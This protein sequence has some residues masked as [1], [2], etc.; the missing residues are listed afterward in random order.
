M[1]IYLTK[2]GY[3]TK[4]IQDRIKKARNMDRTQ[5][6]NPPTA[7]IIGQKCLPL[8]TTHNPQNRNITPFVRHLNGILKTDDKMP[9]ALQKF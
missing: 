6:I 3:L 9:K 1:H 2:Q 5:L 7:E 8:V 4:I